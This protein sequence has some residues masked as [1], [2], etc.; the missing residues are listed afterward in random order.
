M[1]KKWEWQ[2]TRYD[3]FQDNFTDFVFYVLKELGL[4]DE[5]GTLYFFV[6]AICHTT[7]AS[8]K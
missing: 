6:V 8:I 7:H 2:G 4:N 5:I 3:I 1:H